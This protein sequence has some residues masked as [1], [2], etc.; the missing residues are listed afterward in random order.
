MKNYSELTRL[1]SELSQLKSSISQQLK[2][3]QEKFRIQL[4]L[5]KSENCN[6]NESIK[7]LSEEN[8]LLKDHLKNSE[9][10]IT[11]LEKENE[12]LTQSLE[13]ES[14]N[15]LENSEEFQYQV[16][17]LNEKIK[18]FHALLKAEKLKTL[19][20][21][22]EKS[23]IQEIGEMTQKNNEKKVIELSNE[24]NKEREKL[25][26][27][28]QQLESRNKVVQSADLENLSALNDHLAVKQRTIEN[29]FNEKETLV[30]LLE[31]EVFGM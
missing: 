28:K 1:S 30:A 10:K 12:E 25:N 26:E 18:N 22:R 20:T 11:R 5:Q 15:T 27:L 14:T 6:I 4:D 17:V 7:Q 8:L 21:M 31:F 24:V 29:L 16:S 9:T 3:S 2:E 19:D 13:F 23:E